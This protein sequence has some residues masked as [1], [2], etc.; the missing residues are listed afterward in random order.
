MK[1]IIILLFTLI[2]LTGCISNTTTYECISG[3]DYQIPAS[4]TTKIESVEG[5]ITKIEEM[6]IISSDV[7]ENKDSLIKVN[8]A[9][10]I[11]SEAAGF[12]YSYEFSENDSI[13]TEITIIEVEKLNKDYLENDFMLDLMNGYN[14]EDYIE[15]MET[16]GHICKIQ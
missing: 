11:Q 1:K 8:E 9:Y 3:E 13:F 15:G 7:V 10:K 4:V 16:A 2:L 5:S 14:V 12:E 6:M